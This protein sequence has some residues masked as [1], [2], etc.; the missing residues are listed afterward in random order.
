MSV[1]TETA[2]TRTTGSAWR[3]FWSREDWWAIWIGLG[4]VAASCL[5][6][7]QGANLRWLA[8]L[9]SKEG[10]LVDPE[11]PEDNL[12]FT[13]SLE[14]AV[15][16]VRSGACQ[17]A[18]LPPPETAHAVLEV[19]SQGHVMPQKATYF[20]PKLRSGVVLS[21]LDEPLPRPWTE[22]AGDGG[23][24]ETRLPKV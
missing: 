1:T 9:L 22:V 11:R 15:Q 2:A 6:F 18:V 8:V 24:P 23:K 10:E 14:E 17:L 12:R 13:R 3:E 19:A 7:W 21:P 16:A 20:V 4:I 5:L